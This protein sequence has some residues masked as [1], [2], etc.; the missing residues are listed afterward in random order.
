[1]EVLENANAG[2]GAVG[3]FLFCFSKALR[4]PESTP[5]RRPRSDGD[6]DAR[7]EVCKDGDQPPE[8]V[9]RCGGGGMTKKP[10]LTS[11]WRTL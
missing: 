1:M 5:T 8:R 6:V 4:K 3:A 9:C 7:T 10:I 11:F 2:S